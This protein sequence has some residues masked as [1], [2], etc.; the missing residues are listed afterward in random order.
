MASTYAFGVLCLSRL[1]HGFNC[2]TDK[3]LFGKKLMFNNKYL[4]G[5]YL[6][7]VLLLG[8]VFLVPGL[9][10]VFKVVTLDVMQLLTIVVLAALVVPVIQIAKW[11]K[12]KIT[13]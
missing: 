9:R 3:C 4:I 8:T 7:G 2:K 13:K 10:G 5:A 1:F 6:I 12:E 11:L